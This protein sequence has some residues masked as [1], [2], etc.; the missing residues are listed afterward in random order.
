MRR[1]ISCRLKLRAILCAVAVAF[2]F[3]CAP[4][5]VAFAQSV[6]HPAWVAHASAPRVVGPY[7]FPRRPRFPVRLTFPIL[8]PPN[9]R[10]WGVPLYGFGLGLGFN[11]IWWR[12]CPNWVWEYDCYPLPVY[13]IYIVGGGSRELAQ[14]YLKDGTVYN[15]TDYW[16]VNNQ[17]HFTTVE[18]TG[19]N[20]VEHTIDFGQLDLQ[21]TI[22]VATQRGFRFV[23][24]DEPLQQYL[25][26]HPENGEPGTV[27]P[28]SAKPQQE[29]MPQQPQQ[30]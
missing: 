1:L 23:L 2:V 24:R 20:W 21:R 19:T 26:D 30:P 27:P 29:P 8:A 11:P 22:D 18:E 17:L 15:V 6:R 7:Y 5:T 13:P 9:F 25:Q 12:N 16:L 4:G 3:S 28:A 10:F 14:L